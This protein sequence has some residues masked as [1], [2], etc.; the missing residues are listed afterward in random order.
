MSH[1]RTIGLVI[2]IGLVAALRTPAFA[3]LALLLP[4][5]DNTLY[6]DQFGTLS[7][8]AGKYM[9]TGNTAGGAKRRALLKFDLAAIPAGSTITDVQLTLHLSRTINAAEYVDLHRTLSDWGEGAS[10]AF[11]EEG[12]GAPAQPG[13]ATWLHTHYNT[14]FWT[15]PGGDFAPIA[16]ASQLVVGEFHYT[17]TATPRLLDDV[18]DWLDNPAIN[19]GWLIKTEEGFP[20]TAKR[21]DTK[22]N[23]NPDYRPRLHIEYTPIPEP[24]A[25]PL[26]AFVGVYSRRMT[27]SS[28][29]IFSQSARNRPAA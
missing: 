17:W 20:T 21:F 24:A 1:R 3:D 25:L 11:G 13:E 6:E 10:V 18:Q 29:K 15:T 9:F 8:G 26:I 16:S 12:G 23:P 5:Q 14:Q 4:T 28:R 22:E 27:G 2:A 7:N 19:H